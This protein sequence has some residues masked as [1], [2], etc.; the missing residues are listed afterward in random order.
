MYDPSIGRWL[1]EDPIEFAGG[2]ANL[3]RYAGNDPTNRTDPTGLAAP[4]VRG[5]QTRGG[6]AEKIARPTFAFDEAGVKGAG[7]IQI[8]KNV[9]TMLADEASFSPNSSIQFALKSNFPLDANW[10]WIQAFKYQMYQRGRELVGPVFV[11]PSVKY[12]TGKNGEA[13]LPRSEAQFLMGQ[14]YLDHNR[15]ETNRPELAFY[16]VRNVATRRYPNELTIF[17]QPNPKWSKDM[18]SAWPATILF[19]G[20]LYLV[21]GKK[22]Y[23]HVVWQREFEQANAKAPWTQTYRIVKAEPTNEVPPWAKGATIPGGW[24]DLDVTT[25]KLSHPLNYVNPL[26]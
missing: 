7:T 16:D 9:G 10:H 25:F 11:Y 8:V 22:T 14:T 20:D 6:E 19:T 3:E 21:H 26:R 23:Y 24:R 17:D 2:D 18:V 12:T 13:A 5:T 1:E 4:F 15:Q